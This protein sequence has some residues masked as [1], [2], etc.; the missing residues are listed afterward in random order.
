V[1]HF[2]APWK[3]LIRPAFFV[4]FLILGFRARRSQRAALTFIAYTIAVSLLIG[5]TQ[6]EAWPFSD[7]A[8]VHTLREPDMNRW[9]F[10]GIDANGRAWMIDPRVMQPIATEEFD[11]WM[12]M[13]FFRMSG[14]GRQ[15]VSEE[16]IR[17]A[18]EGRIRFLAGGSPGSDEWL[19]G[20]FAA[21]RHFHNGAVWR[22]PND[23]PRVPFRRFR[24]V[25]TRWNIEQF[26]RDHNALTRTVIYESH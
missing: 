24:L 18:E 9:D 22:S 23:V 16:I 15:A 26:E 3:D 7:W 13:K 11:T 19:F 5:F 12:R 21:P 1:I 25:V 14:S 17:R 6:L 8:L 10:V 2:L 4:F 20:R